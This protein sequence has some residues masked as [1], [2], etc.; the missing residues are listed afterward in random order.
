MYVPMPPLYTRSTGAVRMV[1]MSWSGVIRPGAAPSA[2]AASGLSSIAFADRGN[3]P[4][5]AE[6]SAGS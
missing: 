4:P 5:P 1:E 2:W 6:M 3:T